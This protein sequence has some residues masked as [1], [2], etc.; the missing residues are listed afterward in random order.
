MIE[1][2]V[3]RE[4]VSHALAR[5]RQDFRRRQAAHDELDDAISAW[6]G[7]RTAYDAFHALQA[8]G[9]A[10]GVA[11]LPIELLSD[12]HLE[13]RGFIQSGSVAIN[14]T[15]AAALE[16]QIAD[17]ERLERA[18]QV[19]DEVRAGLSPEDKVAAIQS[20]LQVMSTPPLGRFSYQS[21]RVRAG[22][23]VQHEHRR[24]A[25]IYDHDHA[26]CGAHR[27]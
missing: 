4:H 11:R 13:A 22:G 3:S 7:T 14:G 9:V 21:G 16:H 15:K 2:G 1:M 5:Q 18:M 8:A 23:T 19:L 27:H 10:S 20:L 24:A 6:S 12:S 17:D 26:D 25:G